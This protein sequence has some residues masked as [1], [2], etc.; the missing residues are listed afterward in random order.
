MK[1]IIITID[2][3]GDNLW[4]YR[5]GEKIFTKNSHFLPRFQELCNKY[6][7]KPV[8]LVNYEMAQDEFFVNFGYEV[9]KNDQAEIGL[10][11]HAWNNPPYYEIKK[12]YSN[13]GLPYL[14]EYPESIMYEKIKFLIDLIKNKFKCNTFTHRAGRWAMNQDY[15]NILIQNDIKID[16]SVTPH[17]SWSKAI[18]FSQNAKGSDYKNFSE[19]PFTIKH[20][21]SEN[22]ILEVP[23]TIRN[24]HGFYIDKKEKFNFRVFAS[25]LKKTMAYK[26]VWLRPNGKNLAEMLA[27]V[28]HIKNSPS[29]YLMFMLHSSE[30]MPGGSPTFKNIESINNLY[31][32][33][34]LLFNKIS[35]DFSGITLKEYYYCLNEES[36]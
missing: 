5:L 17:K 24:L 3:E 8:Y 23:V 16:C 21:K 4:E 12:Y 9:L 11:L 35:K 25:S 22:T 7:F 30:L 1:Y 19:E 2:T 26:P 33:L 20:S 27:L 14:I 29:S 13:Y 28:K 32:H 10:H 18:G 6:S 34:E 31:L 36:F 15:F